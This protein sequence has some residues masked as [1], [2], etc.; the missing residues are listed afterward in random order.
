MVGRTVPVLLEKPG[1]LPGQMVGRSPWLL[2][3][4]LQADAAE[5]GT[6][7]QARIRAAEANSLAAERAA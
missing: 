2:A 7:V 6:I 4:H 1:R 5:A 3:V